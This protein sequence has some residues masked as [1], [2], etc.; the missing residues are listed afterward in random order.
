MNTA[1]WM[2]E[3]LEEGLWHEMPFEVDGVTYNALGQYLIAEKARLFEDYQSLKMILHTSDVFRLQQLGERII[4]FDE[5]I[6]LEHYN[7]FLNKGI[8]EKIRAMRKF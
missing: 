3:E 4:H 7:D 2:D 6:W 1:V 8:Y 5:S